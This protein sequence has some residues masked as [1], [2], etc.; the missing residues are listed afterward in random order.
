MKRGLV[1]ISYRR[2][3]GAEL[4]RNI[5]DALRRRHFEVFMDV[6]DLRGGAFNRALLHKIDAASDFVIVLTPGCLER[7]FDDTGDWLRLEAAYALKRRKNVVPVLHR[8]FEWPKRALPHDLSDL[9]HQHGLSASHDYFD[10]SM[11]KLAERLLVGW[12]HGRFSWGALR[13]FFGLATTGASDNDASDAA[14]EMRPA[15]NGQPQATP[16]EAAL[17]RPDRS[18]LPPG[19][20]PAIAPS[21]GKVRIVLQDPATGTAMSPSLGR[22]RLVT[23]TRS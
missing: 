12:G 6:E 7:C 23:S 4:A 15:G 1:F 22:V 5:R 9:A 20:A 19:A 8:R 21:L 11:D 10:A 17:P 13:A 18:V 3:G 16:Q 14:P 2:E